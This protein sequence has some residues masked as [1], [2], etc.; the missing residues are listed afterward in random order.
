MTEFMVEISELFIYQAKS[1][2]SSK[3]EKPFFNPVILKLCAAAQYCAVRKLK[4]CQ[5][6]FNSTK[7]ISDFLVFWTRK[8]PTI[9]CRDP[10]SDYNI[11]FKAEPIALVFATTL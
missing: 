5:K 2:L 7:D 11:H 6:N 1:Y 10:K 9:I 8:V 4:M 3:P